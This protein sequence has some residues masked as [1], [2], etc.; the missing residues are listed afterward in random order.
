MSLVSM[1]NAALSRRT[2]FPPVSG[3][4]KG[5]AQIAA[6]ANGDAK[7]DTAV[8]AAM[9]VVTSYIP[10]EVVTLY[11][12]VLGALS[13]PG[14]TGAPAPVPQGLFWGFLIG[15]VVATWM[16]FA[17][18][19]KAAGRGLPL[20]PRNWPAWEMG[21]GAVSFA[22]WAVAMPQNPFVQSPWYTPAVAGI[23]VLVT[24]A[25][26]GLAAPVFQRPLDAS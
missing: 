15:T 1:A 2:D 21:A 4:P 20:L 16:T 26:L 17:A 25:V 24:A 6:A 12:A 23:V 5:Q 8:T 18:K 3:T 11:V 22:A 9:K 14:G 13:A 10:T 7:P 19:L